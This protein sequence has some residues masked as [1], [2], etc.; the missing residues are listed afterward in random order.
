M[1]GFYTE[2]CKII[3]VKFRESLSKFSAVTPKIAL[4]WRNIPASYFHN[5][6]ECF[7][8]MYFDNELMM[9]RA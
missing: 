7:Y 9:M 6:Q 1:E 2:F 8:T 4:L 3:P 5:R